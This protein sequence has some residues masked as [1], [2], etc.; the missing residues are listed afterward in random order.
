MKARIVS[1]FSI[2]AAI[3]LYC[4]I[5]QA[6]EPSHEHSRYTKI[7]ADGEP[8]KPWQGP[9]ACVLDHQSNL[10]WEVKTDNESIHDGYWT[11]SW[12]NNHTGEENLGDCYFEPARCDTQDLVRRTNR[13]ELCGVKNWRLPTHTELQSLVEAPTRP[14][15]T[16]IAHDYFIHI[17]HGDYWTS[18]SDDQLPAHFEQFQMG[19][20]A[21]NFHTGQSMTLPYRNAAFTMLVSTAPNLTAF[22]LNTPRLSNRTSVITQPKENDK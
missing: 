18:D 14:S 12:F 2:L 6:A 1:S 13:D 10:L 15:S 20:K 7:S 8:L 22:K 3:T 21:V 4:S 5:E 9:W 11:Y 19:G 16:H 17:K